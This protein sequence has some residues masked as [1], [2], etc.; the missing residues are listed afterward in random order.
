MP[1]FSNPSLFPHCGWRKNPEIRKPGSC[2]QGNKESRR[3]E[4]SGS[5]L[6]DCRI[7]R[8][9]WTVR[10]W[11]KCEQN[12]SKREPT[13]SQAG[14][15]K[16]TPRFLPLGFREVIDV[17]SAFKFVNCSE[18]HEE[19]LICNLL[20]VCPQELALCLAH[21]QLSS[22]SLVFLPLGRAF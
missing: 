21:H 1:H 7:R 6:G 9:R 16:M 4:D 20:R 12:M 8:Q 22:L 15:E 14:S 18:D 10:I 3:G 2:L 17:S 11:T 5:W 19:C 13:S